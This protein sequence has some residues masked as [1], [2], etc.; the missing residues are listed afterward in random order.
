[1]RSFC[2]FYKF[3]RRYQDS[4]LLVEFVFNERFD[5]KHVKICRNCVWWEPINE[6]LIFDELVAKF[7]SI[8]FLQFAIGNAGFVGKIPCWYDFDKLSISWL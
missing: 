3:R 1:M 5:A 8:F 4:D 2:C 6:K 7:P